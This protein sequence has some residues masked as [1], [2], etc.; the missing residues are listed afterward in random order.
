MWSLL[1]LTYSPKGSL[2]S[3]APKV[4]KSMAGVSLP[5]ILIVLSRY[6]LLYIYICYI[7]EADDDYDDHNDDSKPPQSVIGNHVPPLSWDR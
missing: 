7:L 1:S 3:Q 6:V 5:H 4:Q 2:L